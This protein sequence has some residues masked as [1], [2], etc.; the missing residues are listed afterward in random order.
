MVVA[1]GFPTRSRLTRLR[2]A[3][4]LALSDLVHTTE[5]WTTNSR[6]RWC[7]L[8]LA[9]PVSVFVRDRQ[10]RRSDRITGMLCGDR[11]RRLVHGQYDV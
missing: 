9:L 11:Q 3:L 6:T 7:Q 10:S 1:L 2:L 4:T 8:P 5:M